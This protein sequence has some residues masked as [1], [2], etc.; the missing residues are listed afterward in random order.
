M[1]RKP[2]KLTNVYRCRWKPCG[3]VLAQ[4]AGRGRPKQ[5]CCTSHKQAANLERKVARVRGA[6]AAA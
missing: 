1:P 5:Y 4:K 2:V 3:V 6:A